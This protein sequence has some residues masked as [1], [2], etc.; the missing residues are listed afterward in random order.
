MRMAQS[1][2]I[3]MKMGN[4]SHFAVFATV[5]SCLLIRSLPAF[6]G[7]AGAE[8][9]PSSFE[10]PVEKYSKPELG[11]VEATQSLTPTPGALPDGPYTP[12][13]GAGYS[14]DV[15]TPEP[16]LLSAGAIG[17]VVFACRRRNRRP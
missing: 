4:V 2:Q 11:P 1:E 17:A 6:G 5:M 14:T 15:S 13:W 3:R 7:E 8:R 10:D 16:S 9:G 12:N